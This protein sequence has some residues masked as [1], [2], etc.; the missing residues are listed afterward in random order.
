MMLAAETQNL[1]QLDKEVSLCI[2]LT[3]F[4]E[5][6]TVITNQKMKLN[7]SKGIVNETWSFNS[8]YGK[9][10]QDGG[11]EKRELKPF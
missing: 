9:N 4:G 1:H 10:Y 2:S 11:Q 8:W 5:S 7:H 3:V 6:A